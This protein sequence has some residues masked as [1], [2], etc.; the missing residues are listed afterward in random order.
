MI[1]SKPSKPSS[2]VTPL[3]VIV[4]YRQKQGKWK[5]HISKEAYKFSSAHMTI[6][7]D[8]TKEPLH[9]HNYRVHVTI[10]LKDASFAGMID[11]SQFKK[12]IFALCDKYD[13][14]ILLPKDNPKL[15]IT[16]ESDNFKV[17]FEDKTYSFPASDVMILGIENTTVELLAMQFVRELADAFVSDID[18]GRLGIVTSL[19]VRIDE[20]DGQ[21]ASYELEF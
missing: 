20:T 19:A 15:Q 21:G 9:G 6:F 5:L 11:F 18:R 4:M 13:E 3:T 8:G 7:P 2:K 10:G 12:S 14:K 1:A 16:R 17:V